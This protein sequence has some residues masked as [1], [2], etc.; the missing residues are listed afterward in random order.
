MSAT[1]ASRRNAT[2]ALQVA[3]GGDKTPAAVEQGH[4]GVEP[5]PSERAAGALTVASRLLFLAWVVALNF[6]PVTNNDFWF[7]LR[8]G[9]DIL[10]SGAI[11]RIDVYSGVAQGRPFVEQGWLAA[12]VMA[13]IQ[14]HLGPWG[15]TLLGE[16]A[17]IVTVMFLYLAV[18]REQRRTPWALPLLAL[19]FYL[20]AFAIG[21]RPQLFAI[22]ILAVFV[23][24]LERWRR[25]RRARDIAL[26]V[27]IEILW[28]NLH[29]SFLFAP[30]FLWGLVGICVALVLRP[31]LQAAPDEAAYTWRDVR[32]LAL[33]ALGCSIAILATPYGSA[34]V[35]VA[36]QT[37]SANDFVRQSMSEWQGPFDTVSYFRDHFEYLFWAYCALLALLGG[38]LV[39]R[40]R[41]RPVLDC[42]VV[43]VTVYLSVRGNRFIPYAAMF[44]YPVLVR[45]ANI[46]AARFAPVAMPAMAVAGMELIVS[47]V[48]YVGTIALGY[49]YGTAARGVVGWGIA[50]P[51]PRPAAALIHERG[52]TGVLYNELLTDGSYL[53]HE[54][55]PRVRPV[56]DA[57]LGGD[58]RLYAEYES[59][60]SRPDLLASYLAK[61]DVRLALV[62]PGNWIA[63]HLAADPHWQVVSRTPQR[64]L[65]L[66]Q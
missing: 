48:L 18:P 33:V 50:E 6:R 54:L 43:G 9:E 19:C 63:A 56:M 61:Y 17:G 25:T 30:V 55:F 53:L 62:L 38:A 58:E 10:A 12:V 23:Y 21:A 26:L 28:T 34:S 11:P 5:K 16:L 57:H 31:G 7:H 65:F 37:W 15:F 2:T 51:I 42:A 14:R 47:A 60:R 39:L 3:S 66:R 20:T 1:R 36:L 29:G 46:L 44:G 45:S 64:L 35:G 40:L 41:E 32:S 52:W 13:L 59:I 49:P 27:P 24:C 8:V 4:R 22:P